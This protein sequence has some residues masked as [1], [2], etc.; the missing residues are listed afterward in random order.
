MRP[1]HRGT[2]PFLEGSQPFDA[3][4]LR[5]PSGQM[6]CVDHQLVG[7][8]GLCRQS[9]KYTVEHAG[10]VPADEAVVDCL[11]RAIVPGRIQSAQAVADHE[12]DTADHPS[13][14]DPRNAV[15]QWEIWQDTAHLRLRQPNQIAHDNASSAPPSNQSVVP[16]ASTLMGPE[17]SSTDKQCGVR[18]TACGLSCGITRS[19]YFICARIRPSSRSSEKARRANAV[20]KPRSA[21]RANFQHYHRIC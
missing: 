6:R 4:W 21:Q 13:I 15:R 7:L 12:D 16:D 11:V 1:I 8:A 14:I 20:L 19:L 17:H 5:R 2:S 10:P 18:R 3:R 9:C